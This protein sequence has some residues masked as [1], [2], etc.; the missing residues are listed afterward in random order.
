MDH[1]SPEDLQSEHYHSVGEPDKVNKGK[2]KVTNSITM[3]AQQTSTTDTTPHALSNGKDT[4]RIDPVF[5]DIMRI[6]TG[7]SASPLFKKKKEE[8][9]EEEE[10]KAAKRILLANS[11]LPRSFM[12]QTTEPLATRGATQNFSASS[13]SLPTEHSKTFKN[14][15]GIPFVE[16]GP[17]S[18]PFMGNLRASPVL[19]DQQEP[20]G[21]KQMAPINNSE[22]ANMSLTK[23]NISTL[24]LPP[25]RP[26]PSLPQSSASTTKNDV[27]LLSTAILDHYDYEN[28]SIFEQVLCKVVS[29]SQEALDDKSIKTQKHKGAGDSVQREASN[30]STTALSLTPNSGISDT[31]T[32][33]FAIAKNK[34]AEPIVSSNESK[35]HDDIL[36]G[37]QVAVAAACDED[38]DAQITEMSGYSVR[39][40]LTDL[41]AFEASG[42]NL[43][44][45]DATR[46]AGKRS[47]EYDM[48]VKAQGHA[49]EQNQRK[50]QIQRPKGRGR[51]QRVLAVDKS[52]RNDALLAEMLD[53]RRVRAVENVKERAVAMG[54]RARSVSAGG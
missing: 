47:K 31:S 11:K 39:K 17:V 27:R 40:I 26:A 15:N 46:I 42:F 29:S 37:L 45:R 36:K 28:T 30:P 25:T 14:R 8:E 2:S 20:I 21:I 1:K 9:E 4:L 52:P 12:K 7:L 41:R 5:Q 38:V 48:R 24:S 10:Y 6:N 49:P 44:M 22:Y 19:L 35:I 54:W 23:S 53:S 34:E 32:I 18:E 16:S 43:P 3:L 13:K 33:Y 50:P 51:K